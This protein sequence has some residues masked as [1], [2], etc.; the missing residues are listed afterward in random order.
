MIVKNSEFIISVADVDK[1]PDY[2]APEIAVAGR[3]NVGKSSF[4]NMLTG[5]IKLAKTGKEPGVTRL[6]NYFKINNEFYLVDLPGYGFA[7]VS[8]GE[9][10]KWGTLIEGYFRNSKNLKN[11][12]LLL[13]IRRDPSEG[14]ITMVNYLYHYM[15]P[16]TAILTKSDKLSRNAA[17]A[18]KRAIASALKMGE[19]NL[20]ITSSLSKT[21]KED[22]LKRIADIIAN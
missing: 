12:L 16:F 9:K 2:S 10:E 4:I 8:Q 19:D 18:R 22:V 17:Q 7:R 15:I 3:S 14:D 20:I 13:D 6:I 21:G 5:R 1:I 11:V